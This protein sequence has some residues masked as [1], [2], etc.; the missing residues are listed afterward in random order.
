M[1]FPFSVLV[2]VDRG[3]GI[4]DR[5]CQSVF[6][7]GVHE[8]MDLSLPRSARSLMNFRLVNGRVFD[9]LLFWILE[10]FPKNNL[11]CWYILMILVHEHV[12]PDA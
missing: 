5:L 11:K 1:L 3:D 4:C 6:H 7:S 2:P 9:D 10:K 12:K 8:C